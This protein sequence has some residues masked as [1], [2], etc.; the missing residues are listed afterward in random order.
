M[1]VW[2]CV[3]CCCSKFADEYESHL[4][5]VA[6]TDTLIAIFSVRLLSILLLLSSLPIVFHCFDGRDVFASAQS[7]LKFSTCRQIEQQIQSWLA[8]GVLTSRP[9]A[10]SF[11]FRC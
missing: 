3:R 2:F 5:A 4:G 6:S 9:R 10:G 8:F 1:L 11:F 7:M